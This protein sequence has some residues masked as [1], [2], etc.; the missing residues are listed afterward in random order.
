MTKVGAQI[1]T[2][3]YL[4]DNSRKCPFFTLKLPNYFTLPDMTNEQ[5]DEL[6]AEISRTPLITCE[7][8]RLLKAVKKKGADCDDVKQLEQ[9][10][11]RFEVSLVVQYQH[12]GLS[13]EE[14]SKAGKSRLS[15]M[16]PGTMNKLLTKQ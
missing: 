16:Q 7:E 12:R 15:Q 3:N 10:D 14:L 5:K 11:M 2:T 4:S 6:L 1:E 8:E 13:F 9:A